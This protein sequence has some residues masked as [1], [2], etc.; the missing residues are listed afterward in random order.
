MKKALSLILALV[1]C[2]SLC[3]C[4]DG[5]DKNES[6]PPVQTE[7]GATKDTV[8]T[9]EVIA[10]PIQLQLGEKAKTD[11][12]ELVIDDLSFSAT[13]SKYNLSPD[14]D[15]YWTGDHN[16]TFA[17]FKF[18]LT[19][20]SK[21][22]LDLDEICE[23]SIDYNNGFIYGEK[24]TGSYA[25]AINAFGYIHYYEGLG[26]GTS[27]S[28]DPLTPK[29]C[30]G[31]IECPITVAEDESSSFKIVVKL[32]SSTGFETFEYIVR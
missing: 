15:G 21:N 22:K 3:A 28:F 27:L 25:D 2:L 29:L 13:V 10:P 19:N 5:Q 1:L 31:C 26:Q 12:A 7:P 8:P 32:A 9:E 11:L 24:M 17:C 4:S 30:R 20:N 23:F 16:T 14:G 18:T 6:T